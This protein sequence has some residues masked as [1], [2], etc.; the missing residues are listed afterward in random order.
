MELRTALINGQYSYL[1][2]V[3]LEARAGKAFDITSD[4]RS[5]DFTELAGRST[6]RISLARD[7]WNQIATEFPDGY[8]KIVFNISLIY[9]PEGQL[10]F[11]TVSLQYVK[12]GSVNRDERKLSIRSVFKNR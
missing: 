7:A 5:L 3:I 11:G 12:F 6:G 2:I 1:K 9:A 10:T 4:L 8:K